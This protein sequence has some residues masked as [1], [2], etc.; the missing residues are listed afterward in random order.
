MYSLQLKTLQIF[1]VQSVRNNR[2]AKQTIERFLN[3]YFL[4]QGTQQSGKAGGLNIHPV[5]GGKNI[6]VSDSDGDSLYGPPFIQIVN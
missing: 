2:R 5:W 1:N 4:L 3:V 6:R